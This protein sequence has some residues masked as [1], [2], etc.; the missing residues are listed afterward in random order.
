[1]PW[2]YLAVTGPNEQSYV[3]GDTWVSGPS[4]ECERCGCVRLF[5][6]FRIID[7]EDSLPRWEQVALHGFDWASLAPMNAPSCDVLERPVVG[8]VDELGE[9][10]VAA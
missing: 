9:G 1:M 8:D 2:G 5:A 4:Y 6:S 7:P 10:S 3:A